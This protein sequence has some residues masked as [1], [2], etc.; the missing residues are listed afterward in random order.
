MASDEVVVPMNL[1]KSVLLTDLCTEIN[2]Y[3]YGTPGVYVCLLMP[4]VLDEQTRFTPSLVAAVNH[5]RLKQCEP[6]QDGFYGAPNFVFDVFDR[7]E[8]AEYE[9]RRGAFASAGVCEYVVVFT[10]TQECLWNRLEEGA[11]ELCHPDGDGVLKSKAL[12]GL[13]FRTSSAEDSECWSLVGMVERG[14]T[15]LGHHMLM[16][17]IFHPD[18]RKAEWGDWMPFDA[19]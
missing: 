3:R 19:G 5:G 6:R 16:E 13:W 17:T 10:D 7:S 15:R 4:V 9:A 2:R 11:F 14:L 1:P 18:G 12:P 8:F